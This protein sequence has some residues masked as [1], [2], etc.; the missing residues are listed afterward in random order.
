[1]DAIVGPTS[2]ITAFKIG[3]KMGDPIQMY[4]CDVLTV[5]ANLAGLPAISVPCGLSDGLPAGFQVVGKPFAER[6]VLRLGMIVEEGISFPP[7]PHG[8]RVPG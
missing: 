5:A 4:Q 2:P 7:G 6:D 8:M 1:M 3:E